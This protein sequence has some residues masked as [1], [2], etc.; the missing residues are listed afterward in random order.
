MQTVNENTRV[1]LD[2]RSSYSANGGMIA[3]YQWT[4]L[5]NG[6]PV[7]LT[8][9]NTTTPAFTAPAVPKDTI[10]AFNL[11]VVDN[12]GAVVRLIRPYIMVKN[13]HTVPS[14][15]GG[16]PPHIPVSPN[17]PLPSTLRPVR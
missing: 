16:S 10:F 2:G 6:I 5:P 15:P 13:A 4:Q 14:I 3:A 8:G 1:T 7:T 17:Q 9:A 11:R 12:H